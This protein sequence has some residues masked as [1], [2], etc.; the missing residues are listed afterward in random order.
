MFDAEY[1]HR[2][3]RRAL[4]EAT[5]TVGAAQIAS[6]FVIKARGETPIRIGV[7]LPLTGVYALFGKNERVGCELAVEEINSKGGVLGRQVETLFE[8]STSAD[9]GIAVQ[10]ARKLIVRDKVDVLIGS[11]NSAM[12]H[13][14][15]QVSNEL[16]TLHIVP[17]AL[18]DAVTGTD[19]HW[20]VFRVT[21]SNTMVANAIASSLIKNGGKKWYYITPDYAYGHSIQAALEKA[22]AKF[23]GTKVGGD[24]SPLG[25]SDYSAYLIKAEAAN[26]DVIVLLTQGDDALNSLKQAVQFGL[27]KRFLFAGGVQQLEVLLGLPPEERFGSW[28]LEWYWRQPSVTHVA[29]FVDAVRKKTGKAP[30]SLTWLDYAAV[31]TYALIANEVRTLDALK[32][33]KALEGFE[34]PPEVALMPGKPFYRAADHQMVGASLY[35]GHAQPQGE[36][37]EDVFHVDEVIEGASVAPSETET[38]CSMK[39]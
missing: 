36:E 12:A 22:A 15:G 3:S 19:C 13:A 38:R 28:V 1:S 16:K 6:P 18:S 32:L 25:T 5:I 11:L 33:A 26:P 2:I 23:G 10:K 37:P 39:W 4:I 27:D 9:T 14:T 8:D 21:S 7:N 24:L 34:L 35:V 20:N 17:G 31:W 29:D 30:T